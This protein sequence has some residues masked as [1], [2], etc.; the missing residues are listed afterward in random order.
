M[1]C[2]IIVQQEIHW[3]STQIWGY[4]KKWQRHCSGLTALPP[5]EMHYLLISNIEASLTPVIQRLDGCSPLHPKG[6]SCKPSPSPHSTCRLDGETAMTSTIL[7]RIK[8]WS[9][10]LTPGQNQDRSSRIWGPA[11][12]TMS[13]MGND[14]AD[15]NIPFL[16]FVHH[17]TCEHSPAW[18]SLWSILTTTMRQLLQSPL[19]CH[20]P[21]RQ[22]ILHMNNRAVTLKQDVT[23][24]F[25]WL[26]SVHLSVYS[27]CSSDIPRPNS[28]SSYL[29]L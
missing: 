8:S 1:Y 3:Y 19:P 14:K 20:S 9:T 17:S 28:N 4:S 27:V 10:G 6:H 2:H 7:E 13:K 16:R 23:H 15:C 24:L 25:L 12:Q 26:N 21:Q 18:T 29:N 22:W 5:Q 11:E